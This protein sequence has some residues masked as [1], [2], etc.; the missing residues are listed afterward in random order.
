M[1][2]N[3]FQTLCCEY[4]NT[5]GAPQKINDLRPDTLQIERTKRE[6]TCTLIGMETLNK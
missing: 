6:S 5:F 4:I 3:N 2:L 1:V